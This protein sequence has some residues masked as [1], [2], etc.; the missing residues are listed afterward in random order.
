MENQRTWRKTTNFPQGVNKP[1]HTTFVNHGSFGCELIFPTWDSNKK[2][3]NFWEKTT[4]FP[5]RVN[6]ISHTKYFQV[7]IPT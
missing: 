1:S 7:G 2:I 3:K 4:Y 5:Q 6:K